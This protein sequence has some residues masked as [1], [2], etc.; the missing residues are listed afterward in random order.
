MKKKAIF[1]IILTIIVFFSGLFT[2]PISILTEK[3]FDYGLINETRSFYYS[4]INTNNTKELNLNIAKSEVV[5]KYIHPPNAYAAKIEVFFEISGA[6]ALGKSYQTYFNIIWENSSSTLNFTLVYKAGIDPIEAI[7]LFSNISII[8]SLRADV[9]F[10]I[11]A[12]INEGNFDLSIPFMVPINN[13]NVNLDIGNIDLNYVSCII[14]GNITGKVRLGNIN[15]MAYNVQFTRNTAWNLTIDKGDLLFD[16]TQYKD[17]GANVTGVGEINI[18]E[19]RVLY[20]DYNPDIG[21][22]FIFYHMFNV[23]EDYVE[24]FNILP[25]DIDESQWWLTRF[26]LYTF[27]F[28]GLN[29]YNI[30]LYKLSSNPDAQYV[31]NLLN[32]NSTI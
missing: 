19:L 21:A 5:I 29:Y 15:F 4:P 23:D 9:T 27:D 22:L 8:I 32:T 17:I 1:A 12:I 18:G 26:L 7:S 25:P 13:I 24:G 20:K 2:I 31:Y 6:N 10:D 30:S 3:F 16:I 11:N 14:G 28:P